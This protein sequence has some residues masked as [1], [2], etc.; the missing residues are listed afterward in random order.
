PVPIPPKA[1]RRI[2]TI[3]AV[4]HYTI[5]AIVCWGGPMAIHTKRVQTMLTE[6]QLRELSRLS[7][8]QNKPISLLV[9][10]AIDRVYFQE[11]QRARRR[12][13]LGRL[14]AIEAPVA[15]RA[16]MDAEIARGAPP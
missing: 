14:L 3:L 5:E 15:D 6:E 9:R 1:R 12:A 16:E 8:E 11:Q 4:P 7:A 13:A 10:E 2:H